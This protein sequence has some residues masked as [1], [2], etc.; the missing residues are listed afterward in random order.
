M[1]FILE[2]GVFFNRLISRDCECSLCVS[3]FAKHD[4]RL[5]LNS[6]VQ[7]HIFYFFIM[8]PV[9][10]NSVLQSERVPVTQEIIMELQNGDH[11]R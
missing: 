6:D 4:I 10:Y 7:P 11:M 1:Q 8:L 2:P 5:S 3:R 9:V